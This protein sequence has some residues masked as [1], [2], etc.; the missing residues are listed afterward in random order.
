MM[1]ERFSLAHFAESF[2][3]SYPQLGI[4]NE[5]RMRKQWLDASTYIK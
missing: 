1:G 2:T 4:Q 5:E 3:R